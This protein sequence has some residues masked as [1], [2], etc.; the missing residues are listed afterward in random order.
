MERVGGYFSLIGQE[1]VDF[2]WSALKGVFFFLGQ[3]SAERIASV[4]CLGPSLL[5]YILG[6]AMDRMEHRYA[7]GWA[8]LARK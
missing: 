3:V 6:R 1:S 4:F 7:L 2:I 5:F 8:V